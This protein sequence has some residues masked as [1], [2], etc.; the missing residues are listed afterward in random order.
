LTCAARGREAEKYPG[1]I[2]QL[3]NR[4]EAEGRQVIKRGK[5]FIVTDFEKALFNFT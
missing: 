3:R 5:K 4:L 1:G 2:D